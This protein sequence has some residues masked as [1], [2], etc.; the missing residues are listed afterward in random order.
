MY[1]ASSIVL[2]TTNQCTIIYHNSNSF[3]IH[4]YMFLHFYAII[5]KF[6]ICAMYHVMYV[7][8]TFRHMYHVSTFVRCTIHKYPY[9]G[10]PIP[11]FTSDLVNLSFISLYTMPLYM[12]SSMIHFLLRLQW[13]FVVQLDSVLLWFNCSSPVSVLRKCL[14]AKREA[15]YRQCSQIIHA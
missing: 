10:T 15:E 6:Y 13:V 9:T 3:N 2:I 12:S 7:C 4:F 11:C 8:T 1:H 14:T 5:R